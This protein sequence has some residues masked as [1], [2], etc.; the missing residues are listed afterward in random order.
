MGWQLGAAFC[1]VVTSLD[2]HILGDLPSLRWGH[3]RAEAWGL[4]F[5]QLIGQ[6][7]WQ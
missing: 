2:A 5:A 3:H 4:D 7:R 1:L 6:A